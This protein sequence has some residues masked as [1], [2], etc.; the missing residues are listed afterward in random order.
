MIIIP[1]STMTKTDSPQLF[2]FSMQKANT[3]TP[4]WSK[5]K[6]VVGTLKGST[7]MQGAVELVVSLLE[8][9]QTVQYQVGSQWGQST[10]ASLIQVG[11]QQECCF[12]YGL[13]FRVVSL[14]MQDSK[15]CIG[16]TQLETSSLPQTMA[17]RVGYRSKI[18]SLK[19]AYS[20]VHV[21]QHN[22]LA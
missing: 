12:E 22:P 4:R 1:A 20:P 6:R 17:P 14:V 10:S 21:I 13:P 3:R 7:T 15:L 16:T 11:F 2:C 18:F 5:R 9:L 19:I 8:I